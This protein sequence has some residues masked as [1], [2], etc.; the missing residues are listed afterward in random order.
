M[1]IGL[2]L[3]SGLLL[4]TG[5]IVVVDDTAEAGD[6]TS[7]DGDGDPTGDGDGDPTG[8]GDGDP[9]GDG[10]GDPTG[11]GDGDPT[12][13]GDGD[14]TGDGD[15]DGD[16]D[17]CTP[18]DPGVVLS[19]QPLSIDGGGEGWEQ[20]IDWTCTVSE[21][22]TS[23]GLYAVLDCVDSVDPVVIDIAATPLFLPPVAVDDVIQLRYVYEGPWWFNVYLRLDLDG[24]GHLLTLIDGDSLLPPEP[25]DF[26]LPIPITTASGLCSPAADG[27]GD[28]ERLAL[29]LDLGG[30]L[31]RVFDQNYAIVGGDPGTEVWV[32]KAEHLHDIQCTDTPDEWFR[33]LIADT[34][35]E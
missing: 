9:T 32:A 19:Y 10:D 28:A 8:D 17:A 26:S 11:D 35:Q 4:A 18:V 23:E 2:V 29:D 16:G 25:F 14:P 3:T 24:H 7:G 12:G 1:R 22:D 27:C 34:G 33:L 5:C 31:A 15:G 21:V 6:S 30:E 20:D 13:D